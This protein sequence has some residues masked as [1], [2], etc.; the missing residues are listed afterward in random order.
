[1]RC[2]PDS[3]FQNFHS[4]EPASQLKGIEGEDEAEPNGSRPLVL[5]GM[6]I[7]Y[8]GKLSASVRLNARRSAEF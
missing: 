5:E 1:M 6:A 8:R 3:G 7:R 4:Q 2:A